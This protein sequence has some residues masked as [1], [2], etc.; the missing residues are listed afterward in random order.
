MFL[1]NL[2]NRIYNS[3]RIIRILYLILIDCFSI[4]LSL[5]LAFNFNHNYSKESINWFYLTNIIVAILI[6]YFSGFYFNIT[7]YIGSFTYYNLAIIN[8]LNLFFVYLFGLLFKFEIP[9]LLFFI[10]LLILQTF[11]I[12]SS[13]TLIKDLVLKLKKE[14]NNKVA[15]FGAGEAGSQLLVS[16]ELSGNLNVVAFFDDNQSLW[17]RKINQVPIYSPTKIEELKNS[18]K[19]IFL[20]IPSLKIKRRRE[21]IQMLQE[22]EIPILDIPSIDDLTSG[23]TKINSFR[24][25][26]IDELLGRE[27]IEAQNELMEVAIQNKTILI[28][29]AGGSIG[30]EL[31]KQAMKYKPKKIILVEISEINLYKINEEL[32]SFNKENVPLI[33]ILG[34]SCNFKLINNLIS[35]HK[36]HI[37][38][39][40]AAYKHVPLV[41][42]NPIE[43]IKNN[44]LSTLVIC[45][46]SAKNNIEKVILISTDKSVRPTNVMGASKRVA[47]II[48][49]AYSIKE[50]TK[51]L[52][53]EKYK[54][55]LFSMVR[56]GNVLGSSG[57]VVPKFEKQIKQGGPITITHPKIIRYFM[58]VKE[59][60]QLVIQSSVLS[61]GGDI[62]LLDMGKQIKIVDLAKQ[63]IRLS[64]HSI[65][66]NSNLNGDIEIV[67]TGLRPGEK[68]FEELLIDAESEKTLNPR[69]YRA[70]EGCFSFSELEDKL[71]KLLK[72]LDVYNEDKSLDILYELVPEWKRKN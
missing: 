8:A 24:P 3:P 65:K 41:E 12:V 16:L 4:F 19:K 71:A 59:A 48:I 61:K 46:A 15:I 6:Y 69:I 64:G 55:T 47:E 53:N 32:S 22:I 17:G 67:F 51:N 72:A 49:Q 70:F 11:L 27:T 33:P 37:I 45:K 62:F 35:F 26:P 50:D 58:T 20:A 25:I 30:S 38:F 63:M 21:I 18:F 5:L 34:S 66:D 2:L 13:R 10:E 60:A 68:L 29:G 7:R 44:I 1:I 57:S 36:V 31:C 9:Q 14:N 39:H 54:K 56:F 23:K 52:N 40:A 42:I 28:S 43:G